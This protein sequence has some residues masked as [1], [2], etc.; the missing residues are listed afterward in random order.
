MREDMSKVVIERP[1]R[2]HSLPSSKTRLRVRRYDSDKEYDNLPKRVSGSR[3]KYINAG[4][5]KYFS[6]LLGP[7]RRFLRKNVGRPWDKVY[8]E[9]KERL[10][11]RKAPDRHV[12]EHV[13]GEVETHA[14]IDGDGELYIWSYRV[15]APVYGFYVDPRT[16]LLCW[17][18]NN[19]W[20]KARSKSKSAVE[21]ITHIRLSENS[22]YVK[23]NGIWYFIEF[24]PYEKEEDHDQANHPLR[25]ILIPEISSA[26]LLLLRKKQ[27]SHKELKTAN[28]KNDHLTA[29][30]AEVNQW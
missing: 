5:T 11:D 17:S 20:R 22:S 28:L 7:L 27:L 8:S 26:S 6:D 1:R 10:D 14:L 4:E 21:E 29:V 25:S 2:G 13:D 12:F 9:M 23:L 24:K 30:N 15:R 3:S 18:D 19:P 16:G